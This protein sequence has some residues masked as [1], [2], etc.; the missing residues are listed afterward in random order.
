MG[1]FSAGGLKLSPCKMVLFSG[2]P[3]FIGVKTNLVISPLGVYFGVVLTG[4]DV[5][6]P[7]RGVSGPLRL[8]DFVL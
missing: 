2:I 4:L 5:M 8:G 6:V 7:V 3:L 1:L